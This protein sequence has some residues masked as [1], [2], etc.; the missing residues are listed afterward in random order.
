MSTVKLQINENGAWRNVCTFDRSKLITVAGSTC[1]LAMALGARPKWRIVDMDDRVVL[2]DLRIRVADRSCEI[3]DW[4]EA[5][6]L[7]D[8]DI[9]VLLHM[10]ADSDW[11]I[12]PGYHDGEVW[13]LAEGGKPAQRVA[14]WADMPAGPGLN[15]EVA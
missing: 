8:S 14:R 15:S 2:D 12:W 11:P 5:P 10:P 13:R 4:H 6:D 1:F 9:T 3:L 7:P